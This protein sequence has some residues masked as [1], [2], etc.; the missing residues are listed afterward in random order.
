MSDKKTIADT[1][2]RTTATDHHALRL[3]LRLLA[4]TN[5]IEGH[6]RSRLRSQFDTTLPRF[7]LMAQLERSPN[8]LK[9]GELSKRMMV[10]GGNVTGITDQ[11]V[12]EGLVVRE[13]NPRDRRA[14]I[15]KLTP[16]GQETFARMAVEHE[17]WVIEFFDGMK[18]LDRHQLHGLLASLK[19]H[20]NTISSDRD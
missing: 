20:M 11:L 16:Q 10:T 12:V 4:C 14:Y 17:K 2:T 3:W 7:D 9:M 15:V 13:E 5:L 6:I 8:G 18:E 1:E 19:T